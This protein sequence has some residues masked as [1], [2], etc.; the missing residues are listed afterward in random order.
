MYLR[1]ADIMT[2]RLCIS[3]P[4]IGLS[5]SPFLSLSWLCISVVPV[6]IDIPQVIIY[7]IVALFVSY[8]LTRAHTQSLGAFL[9]VES[10]V[11]S[12]EQNEITSIV[13]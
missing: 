8:V 13:N 3:G 12:A 10:T 1:F 6:V 5:L 9:R 11:L 2:G 7:L 4:P